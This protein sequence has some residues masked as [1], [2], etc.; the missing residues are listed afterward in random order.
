MDLLPTAE[1][2]A[3]AD[4]R[5]WYRPGDARRDRLF[6]EV[7]GSCDLGE[8]EAQFTRAVTFSDEL[9]LAALI[10]HLHH[11][12]QPSCTA[13]LAAAAAVGNGSAV[14]LVLK[15]MPLLSLVC[16]SQALAVAAGNGHAQIVNYLLADERVDPCHENHA[17]TLAAAR[18][19]HADVVR[20]LMFH[21]RRC[22]LTTDDASLAFLEQVIDD[23]LTR[24]PRVR[25]FALEWAAAH[26]RLD[27]VER[28]LADPLVDVVAYGPQALVA[29]AQH[30]RM[31]ALERLLADARID[32]NDSA[33]MP[34]CC[35]RAHSPADPRVLPGFSRDVSD[36]FSYPHADGAAAAAGDPPRPV[37]FGLALTAA[38]SAGQRDAAALLLACP[39]VNPA[40]RYNEPLVE[41]C[42]AGHA[43]IVHLLLSC[44]RVD[45]AARGNEALLWACFSGHLAV[46]ELLLANR[47][48][49]PSA[50]CCAAFIAAA[51][52]GH[53][54]V[55]ERLL[56]DARVDPAARKDAAFCAAAANGHVALVDMLLSRG[57]GAAATPGSLA[58]AL[59]HACAAGHVEA[60]QRLLS[61]PRVDPAARHYAALDK[62]CKQ[63][64]VAVVDVLLA[65]SR[66]EPS[67]AAMSALCEAVTHGRV[68]ATAFLLAHPRVEV[69][70]DAAAYVA[71]ALKKG[72]F[73]PGG[74]D[75][76]RM[77]LADDRFS[78][79]LLTPRF[80]SDVAAL[81]NH[82]VVAALLAD[83]RVDP[84][85]MEFA[86]IHRAAQASGAG[87]LR[88]QRETGDV[89][90][91][92]SACESLA[93]FHASGRVVCDEMGD[94]KLMLATDGDAEAKRVAAITEAAVDE[95]RRS[96]A[97]ERPCDMCS[98]LLALEGEIERVAQLPWSERHAATTKLAAV[99]LRYHTIGS[100]QGG[101]ASSQTPTITA[102]C[103]RLLADVLP[104]TTPIA[105][106][107]AALPATGGGDCCGSVASAELAPQA[108]SL[109]DSDLA[110]KS[111]ICSEF[112]SSDPV[113]RSPRHCGGPSEPEGAEVTHELVSATEDPLAIRMA[114]DAMFRLCTASRYMNSPD[115]VRTRLLLD[116]RSVHISDA[117]IDKL[118]LSC[119][120]NHLFAESELVELLLAL[121]RADFAGRNAEAFA[122]ACRSV[123]RHSL[124]VFAQLLACPGVDRAARNN[125]AVRRVAARCTSLSV[126]ETLLADPGVDPAAK[127]EDGGDALVEAAQ[128]SNVAALKRLL[129]DPRADAMVASSMRL[130]LG[131]ADGLLAA[132]ADFRG[133]SEPLAPALEVLLADPRSDL[134]EHRSSMM[135]RVAVQSASPAAVARLLADPRVT[136]PNF[137]EGDWDGDLITVAVKRGNVAIL[138]S[139]LADAR[140]KPAT[141]VYDERSSLSA[142]AKAGDMRVL[143]LLLGDP[144]I[145]IA[146]E[147]ETA[148]EEALGCGHLNAALL[149]ARCA[150]RARSGLPP[151]EGVGAADHA[152]LKAFDPSLPWPAAIDAL[153]REVRPSAATLLRGVFKR[154]GPPALIAHVLSDILG[155]LR[156]A[157]GNGAVDMPAL[158]A[159]LGEAEVLHPRLRDAT[160]RAMRGSS[161]VLHTWLDVMGAL[162]AAGRGDDS[163]AHIVE[164]IGQ[165]APL[166]ATMRAA[167]WMRRRA[168]VTARLKK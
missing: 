49:D 21:H 76:T 150:A 67:L 15:T 104:A 134:S 81:N 98:T 19:D 68:A 120:S 61:L 2:W 65:D 8:L 96:L 87:A 26:D 160:I 141:W 36:S 86:A 168:A 116:P 109:L 44:P 83:P 154:G 151:L 46:I 85:A 23:P 128:W 145:P 142:A 22:S 138:A 88:Q 156:G 144:R 97:R 66:V 155:K 13:A 92:A 37:R 41:A 51:A 146:D 161:L 162:R 99:Y 79:F 125:V 59:Q 117:S 77:L 30:G 72:K 3:S 121:G 50:R 4:A 75:V 34:L 71:G 20:L 123:D 93:S 158:L 12:E 47:R 101:C 74:A 107:V 43:S 6:A 108:G 94:V 137:D 129:A 166:S 40:A 16:C 35:T 69:T 48:V 45:A 149:I 164:F 152:A 24:G 91:R 70:R 139:V 124:D 58:N 78:G 73:G 127:P 140:V 53:V 122:Q 130:A 42:K 103:E 32:P 106:T 167:A 82:V 7:F 119:C 80:L 57:C 17:A 136:N 100:D 25:A 84:S 115:D 148:A 60:V 1:A 114:I 89:F 90:P 126:L 5:R 11:L 55:A 110:S 112:V 159:V 143:R 33:G 52:R 63:G 10:E 31:S 56:A 133:V 95:S 14:Q 62:A 18:A 118:L 39:R 165:C 28:L 147:G 135:L 113:P 54:A 111:A 131:L 102:C 163:P 38:A 64:H 27:L 157:S 132:N 105:V 153:Q 9:K 29:A